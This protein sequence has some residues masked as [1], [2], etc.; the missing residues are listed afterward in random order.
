[1]NTRPFA[2]PDSKRIAVTMT[3]M[4]AFTLIAALRARRVWVVGLAAGLA[5]AAKYSIVTSAG[6]IVV[7]RVITDY[8]RVTDHKIRWSVP[9]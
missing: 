7:A 2:W 3:A 5:V 1:M 8:R 6:A 4:L 9:R